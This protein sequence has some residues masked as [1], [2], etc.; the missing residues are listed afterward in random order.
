MNSDFREKTVPYTTA[1]HTHLR[2]GDF[3]SVGETKPCKRIRPLVLTAR[4]YD[5]LT[6]KINCNFLQVLLMSINRCTDQICR[7]SISS[8]YGSNVAKFGCKVK[9]AKFGKLCF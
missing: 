1:L 9:V 8:T 6:S 7:K 2:L 5:Y 4:A 3:W